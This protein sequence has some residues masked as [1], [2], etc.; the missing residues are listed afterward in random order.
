MC[1]IL[2]IAIALAFPV[3]IY[4]YTDKNKKIKLLYKW[5]FFYFGRKPNPNSPIIKF[6]KRTTGL[7]RFDDFKNINEHIESHGFTETIESFFSTISSLLHRIKKLL[8][9]C[10]IENFRLKVISATPDS[11]LTAITHG[12]VCSIIYPVL[13]Y[14]FSTTRQKPGSTDI[15]ITG[16]YNLTKPEFSFKTQISVTAYFILAAYLKLVFENRKATE[17]QQ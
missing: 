11:A 5:L 1:I 16:N 13:G 10:T 17:N 8:P 3:K 7:S 6:I 4:A 14:L 15:N 12:A 2:I 9:H